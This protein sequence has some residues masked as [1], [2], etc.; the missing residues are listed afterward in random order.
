[1]KP[2]SKSQLMI[3]GVL[4][5]IHLFLLVNY[6]IMEHKMSPPI[7]CSRASRSVC[8]YTPRSGKN[9]NAHSAEKSRNLLIV[10]ID[11]ETRSTDPF[12]ISNRFLWSFSSM[13]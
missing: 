2:G 6:N 12:S 9:Y 3:R 10:R 13:S 1:M 5:Q 8:H 4:L 11:S 7:P